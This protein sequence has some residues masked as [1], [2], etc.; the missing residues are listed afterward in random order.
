MSEVDG[1]EFPQLRF[2]AVIE[3]R[4]LQR[5]EHL[6]GADGEHGGAAPAGDVAEGMREKG[7]ADADGADDGDVGVRVEEAQRGELVEE[8][9]IEGDLRGAV[10]GVQAHRRDPSGLSAT[11]SVTAR[12]SRRVTSSL[13]TCSRRS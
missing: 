9:A 2:V 7:L 11:R 12:L 8:R 10:P 1:D 6:V 3:A 5:L 13:R 4:V